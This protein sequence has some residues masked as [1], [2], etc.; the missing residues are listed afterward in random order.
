MSRHVRGVR[1]SLVTRTG[2]QPATEEA[3]SDP[4]G[5]LSVRQLTSL[6]RRVGNRAVAGLVPPG[7]QP[8][9]APVVQRRAW[10]AGSPVLPTDPSL[11]ASMRAFARDG[12]VRDYISMA[13]FKNHAGGKTDYLGTL[14]ATSTSP[15]TWVR[16]NPAGT[17]VLGEDHTEVTLE[18][19]MPAVGSKSFI[20]ERLATDDL[21]GRPAMKAAYEAE[22]QAVLANYGVARSPN[23]QLFGAES[24]FP[25]LAFAF[26]L[27]LPYVCG[28]KPL[29]D[30]KPGSYIGDPLQRYLKIGWGHA[31]DVAA[32]VAALKASKQRVPAHLRR[33]AG[34]F[35]ATKAELGTFVTALPVDGFLGD[36]LA[37]RTGRKKL[38]PLERFCRAFLAAMAAHMKSDTG[39]TAAER[40]SL[41]GMPRG[42]P[43]Q[44]HQAFLR[45]RD[46]H[47][48]HTLRAAVSRGVRYAGMGRE[49]MTTLVAE[50][51]P[52]N[53]KAWDMVARDLAAFEALTTSRAASVTGP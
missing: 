24:L 33:L 18:H 47:F 8:W 43:R 51:L 19:V 49:H 20:T 28:M 41:A 35:T 31:A 53:T 3:G 15:G 38:P 4:A 16:F 44:R 7:R 2:R 5:P 42:T 45:W 23:Q 26:N 46:M 11:D 37:T 13:E 14:P 17:N 6:Q 30:L 25:K 32:E 1:G 9:F 36:A 12:V 50:G 27:L 34:V 40:R 10:V 39:I 48:S 29:A 21:S 22:N 52:P